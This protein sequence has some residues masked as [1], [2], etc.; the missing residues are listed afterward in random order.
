MRKRY[1]LVLLLLCVFAFSGCSVL[2]AWI[3]S[4]EST[5]TSLEKVEAYVRENGELLDAC[6]QEL[7]E[8][9]AAYPTGAYRYRIVGGRLQETHDNS[10][11]M[12]KSFLDSDSLTALLTDSPFDLVIASWDSIQFCCKKTGPDRKLVYYLIDDPYAPAAQT[13]LSDETDSTL[14]QGSTDN[15]ICQIADGK[16]YFVEER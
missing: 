1:L 14:L 13:E 7:Q 5:Q 16:F 6:I 8:R 3:S 9:Y 12:P 2:Y 10:G 15:L 11:A 4:Y